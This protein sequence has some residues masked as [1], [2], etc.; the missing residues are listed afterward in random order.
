MVSKFSV[1]R[2]E[3]FMITCACAAP[4]STSMA[5]SANAALSDALRVTRD[6]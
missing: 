5:P 1:T 6:E 3:L 4:D 2:F